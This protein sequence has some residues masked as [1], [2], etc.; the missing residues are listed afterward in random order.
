MPTTTL[1]SLLDTPIDWFLFLVIG[2]TIFYLS[3]AG[4]SYAYFF[5]WRRD[6]FL[7]D[8][9]PDKAENRKAILW[10]LWAIVGGS[11]LIAP[12]H[13]LS[14]HGYTRVYY[15]VDEYGWPWFF[16]S[17]LIYIFVTETMIYWIHRGLHHP[18][19][20]KAIHLKHHEFRKPTP[21][22]GVAFNPL[23]SWLQSVPHHLCALFMPV[24]IGVYAG[25]L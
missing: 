10:G 24:H 21:W 20:Y 8:Y 25:F 2:G 16:A 18:R 1:H 15:D 14:Q 17:V 6:R 22:V 4:L 3:L 13:W 9:V 5:V 11:A 19:I 12:V 7:P 23:D